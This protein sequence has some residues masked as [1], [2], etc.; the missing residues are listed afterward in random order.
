MQEDTPADL[1]DF[2]KF[3]EE[4]PLCFK[5][6]SGFR[7]ERVPYQLA[8]WVDRSPEGKLRIDLNTLLEKLPEQHFLRLNYAKSLHVPFRYDLDRLYDAIEKTEEQNRIFNVIAGLSFFPFP[9]HVPPLWLLLMPVRLGREPVDRDWISPFTITTSIYHKYHSVMKIFSFSGVIEDQ[10]LLDAK[11]ALTN[12]MDRA[13]EYAE[14][15]LLAPLFLK[16]GRQ[17][18]AQFG[19]EDILRVNNE[20]EDRALNR[21]ASVIGSVTINLLRDLEHFIWST[22]DN[23]I[24]MDLMSP[25]RLFLA[26]SQPASEAELGGFAEQT[27]AALD[28]D[29]TTYLRLRME[30]SVAAYE[31]RRQKAGAENILEGL[32]PVESVSYSTG[33]LPNSYFSIHGLKIVM[34]SLYINSLHEEKL[35]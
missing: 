23:G 17:F 18:L 32:P 6:D 14:E 26:E 12:V 25:E 30:L 20:V 21:V 1:R 35:E 24:T 2:T 13:L 22:L 31:I 10:R 15:N 28:R 8:P 29:L 11:S 9:I 7:P 4:N 34:A 33:T 19:S 27:L 5:V 3:D 16:L